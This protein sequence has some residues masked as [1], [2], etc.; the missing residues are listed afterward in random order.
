MES[1]ISHSATKPSGIPWLGEVPAH[2][3]VKRLRFGVNLSNERVEVDADSPLPYIGMEHI[4]SWTG[5]VLPL[6]EDFA[7]TGISNRVHPRQVMFGKLR[8]YLA[9]AAVSQVNGLCSTELMVFQPAQFHE[10]FLLYSLLSDGFIKLIDSST[11]GAKMPRADWEFVGNVQ[12]TLPP[13]PEQRAI[14]AFLDER[15]AR[16][17]GLLARKR[18]LVQLLK[19]KRQALITRAVTHGLDAKVKLRE[20]GLPFTTHVPSHW[21]IPRVKH[22][23][24]LQTGITLGK[25]FPVN[26]K[27]EARPYLRVANVQDGWLKLDDVTLIELPPDDIPYYELRRGDVLMTEGGDFD[28]LGR[29]TV[30]EAEVEGCLHQ[31]HIYAVRT[32]KSRLDPYFLS[33]LLSSAHGRSYFTSN[34]LQ[35][36]NLASTNGTIIKAFPV[37]L[38]P[39]DEQRAILIW[40]QDKLAKL[41]GVVTKVEAAMERLQ[42]YRTALISAAVTGKVRVH[43]LEPNHK[44]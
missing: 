23:A 17:D 35:T 33:F 8:P 5:R 25:Q 38:P 39:L 2:W 6:D 29:G 36:T 15:T 10:R 13:L 11:Q 41:D 21:T 7:P 3:E 31:N 14:A 43:E 26:M 16:I 1:I 22:V 12:V 24:K 34:K 27:L 19:E 42:E 4:E 40:M 28:K 9:K 18:R 37:L 44:P 32:D 20:S 30:W